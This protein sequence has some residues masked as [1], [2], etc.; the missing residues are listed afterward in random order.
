M[1]EI[2]TKHNLQSERWRVGRRSFESGTHPK[3]AGRKPAG[4]PNLRQPGARRHRRDDVISK[5]QRAVSASR[6][7]RCRQSHG[8]VAQVSLTCSWNRFGEIMFSTSIASLT[9]FNSSKK[10]DKFFKLVKFLHLKV[11]CNVFK[12]FKKYRKSVILVFMSRCDFYPGFNFFAC[13]ILFN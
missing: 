7:W 2:V 13:P 1:L 11:S 3:H 4:L 8:A 5:S 9:F 10:S 12:M 6:W